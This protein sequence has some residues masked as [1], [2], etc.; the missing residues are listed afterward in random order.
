M[1]VASEIPLVLDERHTL[2][3]ES[4]C[5]RINGIED[6]VLVHV[7]D[8]AP[9]DDTILPNV[10]TE[11]KLTITGTCSSDDQQQKIP[12]ELNWKHWRDT[13]HFSA[14]GRVTDA[15]KN[16]PYA[17]NGIWNKRK[18]AVVTPM[19]DAP[20]D[21]LGSCMREDDTYF[22]G[23]FKIPQGSY[24]LCPV[25]EVKVLGDLN[26]SL[27]TVAY[28]GDSVMPYINNFINLCGFDYKLKSG[29]GTFF[30][31]SS[32]EQFRDLVAGLGREYSYHYTSVEMLEEMRNTYSEMIINAIG[33]IKPIGELFK[34][35]VEEDFIFRFWLLRDEETVNKLLTR[36]F[37]HETYKG[38]TEK[39][40]KWRKNW[41]RDNTFYDGTD[42]TSELL[43]TFSGLPMQ[44][45][46]PKRKS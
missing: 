37:D 35:M 11:K 17:K 8:F 33:I 44:K 6:I 22:I 42:A 41:F 16:T 12:F 27:S 1:K 24:L 46:E 30:S 36:L 29:N 20:L 4:D 14:N 21:K 26:P 9:K 2:V 28:E 38:T 43:Q 23:A 40:S 10:Q 31:T 39:L 15:N 5:S 25:D 34:Y 18:Y 32:N 45:A 3:T 7:T 19:V 13:V